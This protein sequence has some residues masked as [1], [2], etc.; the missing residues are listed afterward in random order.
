M[1]WVRAAAVAVSGVLMLGGCAAALM[2]RAA[3]TGSSSSGTTSRP[4]AQTSGGASAGP[5]SGST[6]RPSSSGTA[7][8]SAQAGQ[9]QQIASAVRNKL[10]ADAATKSLVVRVDAYQGVVS[11]HGD[12]SKAEQRSA[13]E[14]VARSIAGVREVRNELRVR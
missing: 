8:T 5:S 4:S 10:V 13:A 12:V 11:L 2:G 9:D 6:Q 1:Y 3:S 7:R 14:R